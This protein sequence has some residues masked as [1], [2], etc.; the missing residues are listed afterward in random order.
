MPE[1]KGLSS[2]TI[3]LM[4]GVALFYDVLQILFSWMG[5]GWFI[6]PIAYGHF[7]LLFRMRGL[8]FFT[9][10]RAVWFGF[11][12]PLEALTA[13]IFPSITGNVL[14]SAMDYKIEKTLPTSGIIKS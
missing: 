11:G 4:T 10:K 6:I 12:V 14:R 3:G 5:L 13:G 7:W 8:K 1:K 2:A 9:T